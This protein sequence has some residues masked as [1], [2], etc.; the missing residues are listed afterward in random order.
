MAPIVVRLCILELFGAR[1][2]LELNWKREVPFN[3]ALRINLENKN[4]RMTFSVD[5]RKMHARKGEKYVKRF[6]IL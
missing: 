6:S 3:R 5:W 4:S 1:N 2:N